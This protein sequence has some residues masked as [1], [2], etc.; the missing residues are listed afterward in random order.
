MKVSQIFIYPVKSLSGIALESS[1]VSDRGLEHDRRWVLI[2]NKNYHITQRERPEL[3]RF[4]TT[5]EKEGIRVYDKESKE[6]I[7]IPFNSYEGENEEIGV[8]DDRFLTREVNKKI[9]RW[10]SEKLVMEVRL[11]YQ[12]DTS[13]RFVDEK[14]SI[15]GSE[16]VSNADGYPVLIISEESLSDLNDRLDEEVSIERFRPNIVIEGGKAFSEDQMGKIK[17]GDSLLV[18]VKNC[19]RCVMIN[20]DPH[21]GIRTKEPL[22]TLSAYRREGNKVLFGRN[23]LIERTGKIKV[24]DLI[25][26]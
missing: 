14:F 18:G 24:G 5:L 25:F 26:Q 4:Q 3:M 9:S 1:G 12:L 22:K 21:S 2:D 10:F 20:N 6:A 8:W 11:M 19:A 13:L 7:L 16:V 23:F 17:I 15:S